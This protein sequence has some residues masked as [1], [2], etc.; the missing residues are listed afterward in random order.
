MAQAADASAVA[1]VNQV[2]RWFLDVAPIVGLSLLALMVVVI[3]WRVVTKQPAASAEAFVGLLGILVLLI[4]ILD[5]FSFEGFGLKATG[6]L[7]E[8]RE[9]TINLAKELA[10][11][12]AA[13]AKLQGTIPLS[14]A[15]PDLTTSATTLIFY[16]T[17]RQ[18]EAARVRDAFLEE[19]FPASIVA[20]DFSELGSGASPSGTIRVLV[21][22]SVKTLIAD[23]ERIVG[24]A[25]SKDRL[26]EA[27]VAPIATGKIQIQL[28]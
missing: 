16:N 19:G 28:I 3:V 26:Q 24:N 10:E 1:D 27:R 5:S 25:T 14:N 11:L 21:V 23:V 13:V 7:K 22:E 15:A 6:K 8:A 4:P 17:N 9:N 2:A 20:T 12:S 18:E